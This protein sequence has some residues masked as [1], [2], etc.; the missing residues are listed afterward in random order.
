MAPGYVLLALI[1]DLN[2]LLAGNA[3]AP[4]APVSLLEKVDDYFKNII[5]PFVRFKAVNPR[6]EKVC[7]WIT[8]KLYHGFDEKFYSEKL[9]Q[10]L[11]G[12]IAPWSIG[13]YD[14]L[15]FGQC[16]N[17]SDI[18]RF[19]EG[20]SYVDYILRLEMKHEAEA[21]KRSNVCPLSPR[22]I[23]IAGDIEVKTETE[24]CDEWCPDPV[25]RKDCNHPVLVNDY[26]SERIN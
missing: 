10:D 16:L 22:S 23:L 5:S 2:K 3:L 1:P 9:R 21:E 26:C 19:L 7:F 4:K 13:T 20:R 12:F 25:E 11:S 24:R 18:I 14:K 15:S 6:Y 17:Q 8:V